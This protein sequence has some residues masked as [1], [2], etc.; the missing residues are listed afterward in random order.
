[1]SVATMESAAAVAV[2]AVSDTRAPSNR[3]HREALEATPS[4]IVSGLDLGRVNSSRPSARTGRPS[5]ALQFAHFGVR[6]WDYRLY[7]TY[8]CPYAHR[9]WI[10]RNFKDLQHKIFLVPIDMADRPAWFSKIYPENQVPCLEHNNKM[11]GESLDLIKY[12]DNNFE[13]FAEELLAYLDTFNQAMM[14]AL[15]AKGTVT[16][17][18]EAAL[19]KIEVSLSKFDD[20][21]FFLGQFSLVDI[22]YAPFVDGFQV[23]FVNIKNYNTIAGRPNMQRFIKKM[24]NGGRVKDW[25]CINFSQNVQD[26]AAGNFCH[27]LAGMCQI[28]GMDFSVDPLLPP[29]SARPE[30]VERALKARYR[31]AMN[32]LKPLG[33]ELDLLVAILPDNNGS[34]YG[35]LKRICE[36]DLGWSLNAVVASQ[37]W[38]E[39]TKYAGLV[40]AQTRRQELIQDLFKVWQDPQRIIFYRNGVSEG[41]FYQVLL[42]E[43]DAIRNACAS[44]EPNYQPP[45]TF[46]VVQKR[47][48]TRLFANNHNNQRSVDR[49]SGNKLPGTYIWKSALVFCSTRKGAQEATQCLSQTAGSLGYSN[50]FMKSMQHFFIL[51]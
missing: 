31:D 37:D 34:L 30:H 47:H 23:F 5:A 20:G 41:Q 51:S 11:I 40:S 6:S 48:H 9:A 22:A 4:G 42:Y 43:L 21:P 39:V 46:V 3:A 12:M 26:S 7:M 28:S 49:K 44:L 18:A 8:V 19:N 25:M 32:V 15:K 29:L 50:P 13:G 2:A 36:T 35:N 1:M 27:E 24:D 45:V 16:A 17:D 33:R 10:A 38:P 14:S